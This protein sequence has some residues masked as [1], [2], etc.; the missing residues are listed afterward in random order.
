MKKGLVHIYTGDGKG[1]TTAALGLCLRALGCGYRVC[2]FQLFKDAKFPCGERDAVKKFGRNFKFK[3]FDI[4]HPDFKKCGAAEFK[5]RLNGVILEIERETRAG[6]F[7]MVVLDEILIGPSH[8]FTDEESIL[9]IIRLKPAD[10][11]LVLTGRG[12]GRRLINSADYVTFMKCVKHP[13]NSGIKMRRGVE[14]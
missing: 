4:T 9:R 12:A 14:F 13:F 7:D 1:K 10:T 3:R 8:G 2:F 11:E 6:K 5:K